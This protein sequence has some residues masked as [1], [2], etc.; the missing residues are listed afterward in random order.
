MGGSFRAK[1]AKNRKDRKGSLE[2]TESF[3]QLI[4]V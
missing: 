1:I 2:L 3:H 4:D